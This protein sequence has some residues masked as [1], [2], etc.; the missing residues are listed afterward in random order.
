MILD[1]PNAGYLEHPQLDYWYGLAGKG[2]QFSRAKIPAA[3]KI[4]DANPMAVYKDVS[5]E[6]VYEESGPKCDDKS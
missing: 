6:C 1:D 2:N 4:A 3:R 5:V